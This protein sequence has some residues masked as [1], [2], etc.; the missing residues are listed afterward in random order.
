MKNG[1][2]TLEYDSKLGY[3]NAAIYRNGIGYCGTAICHPEDEDMESELI[4][5][6]I[7]MER[8]KIEFYRHIKN[9]EIAPSL[10]AIKNLYSGI[11]QGKDFNTK[12]Y[13]ARKIRKEIYRL[14]LELKGLKESINETKIS[15]KNYI[16]GKDTLHKAIRDKRKGR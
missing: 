15:L 9:N 4:G 12:S 13:E 6:H 14:E 10:K 3:A 5:S 7:A 2:V 8:A 11:S 1:T 16:D